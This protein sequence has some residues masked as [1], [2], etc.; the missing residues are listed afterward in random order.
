MQEMTVSFS[1][2]Q[3][4]A[5]KGEQSEL[6]LD[7]PVA[8]DVP[9]IFKYKLRAEYEDCVEIVSQEMEAKRGYIIYESIFD[10][11]IEHQIRAK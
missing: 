3:I 10:K 7:I 4:T 1:A 9:D 8:S 2:E 11:K 5:I 6:V